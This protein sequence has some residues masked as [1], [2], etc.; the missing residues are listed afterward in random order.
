MKL[1]SHYIENQT[2]VN[3]EII[4]WTNHI[5]G[6]MLAYSYRDTS[7]DRRTF[8][9]RLHSHDYYEMVVFEEGDIHYICDGTVYYPKYADIM[10]VPPGKFHVAAPDSEKTRY[11]RHVFYFYPAAFDAIGHPALVGFL[12]ELKNGE[13]FSFGSADVRREFSSLLEKMSLLWKGNASPLE[14][15]LALSNIINVFYLLNHKSCKPT[16]S[17][18]I[19]PENVLEL[20]KYIDSEFSQIKNVS[21]V[22]E[23]FFYSRE[24]ISRL[25]K[26][27]FDTT[28]SDYITKRRV[29][30]SQILIMQGVPMVDAAYRVGFG[31]L[32]TFIRAFRSV[33]NMTPSEYRKVRRESMVR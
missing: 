31:S 21:D 18:A 16:K 3:F 4:N 14:D 9:S 30:E 10:L 13:L 27:Y 6:D 11:K 19:L 32:S 15:A 7:Y 20:Q 28:I 17:I 2:K 33:T 8:P 24:Y 1:F 22:A 29:A 5:V 23:H 25:F 12:T 26:K